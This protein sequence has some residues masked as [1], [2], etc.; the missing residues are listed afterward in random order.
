MRK[1]I[2]CLL[3]LLP[4]FH[5]ISAVGWLQ[6]IVKKRFDQRKAV[7]SLDI[8]SL[9]HDAIILNDH[10]NIKRALAK[11]AQTNGLI[12]GYKVEDLLASEDLRLKIFQPL[13]YQERMHERDSDA[14]C[15]I[16]QDID[17]N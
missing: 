17:I 6:R 14:E 8:T 11:G 12:D 3:F 10:K 5:T 16:F 7:K 15:E 2:F 9:L 13:V 4:L 1:N